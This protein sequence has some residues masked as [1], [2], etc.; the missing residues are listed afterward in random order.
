MPPLVRSGRGDDRAAVVELVVAAFVTEPALD[1]LFADGYATF[2]PSFFGYL[3]DKRL[4]SGQVWVSEYDGAV[5]A[6]AMWNLPGV[7]DPT[8]LPSE[9]W[10][11][12]ASR[13]PAEVT[14]RMAEYEQLLAGV[15]PNEEHYYLGV[16]ATHPDFHGRGL[17]SAVLQPTL[18]EADAAALP[19]YLETGT[20]ANI[21]FYTR[22]GFVVDKE[23]D[24][25]DGPRVWWMRRPAWRP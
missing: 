9:D 24:L 4:T 7:V 25:P 1:Y 5:A 14:A 10:D 2:A 21:G 17:G 23:V 13:H 6:V 18:T 8:D 16:I 11:A 3:F 19:A 12:V 22:H 20:E 15:K